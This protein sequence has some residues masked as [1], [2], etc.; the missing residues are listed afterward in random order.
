M[1]ES[2]EKYSDCPNCQAPFPLTDEAASAPVLILLMLR[3][4]IGRFSWL[5]LFPSLA[6]DKATTVL[7][8]WWA[9]WDDYGNGMEVLATIQK[10]MGL[11][12][13]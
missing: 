9:G 7:N 11:A 5:F 4:V 8:T 12:V 2:A 6:M 3:A 1:F 10:N 13:F